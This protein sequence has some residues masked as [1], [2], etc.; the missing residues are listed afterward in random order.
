MFRHKD[1]LKKKNFWKLS[2]TFVVRVDVVLQKMIYT[3]HNIL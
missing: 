1:T 2:K 3:I